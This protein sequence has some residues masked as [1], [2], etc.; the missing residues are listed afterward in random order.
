MPQERKRSQRVRN[1]SAKAARA[2]NRVRETW[3]N[4]N[5][6]T[7]KVIDIRHLGSCPER[8]RRSPG[9]P[10][11]SRLRRGPSALRGRSPVRLLRPALK[12]TQLFEV[13]IWAFAALSDEAL[14]PLLQDRQ[15]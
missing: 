9:R 14:E 3:R 13:R 11:R 5:E 7:D 12:A 4:R 1:V 2:L 8:L 15:G 10:A 6:R